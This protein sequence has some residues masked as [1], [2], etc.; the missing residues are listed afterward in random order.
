MEQTIGKRIMENRKRLGLTQDQLAERLGI[1]AQAVSKWE[2]DQSCPDITML[3]RL[4]E[5]FGVST[6]ALLGREPEIPVHCAEVV[7]DE[8]N[9]PE[10][11]HINKGEWSFQW[12]SGRRGALVFAIFVL[13]SGVLMLLA[14]ILQWDVGFWGIV[15]PV[16]LLAFGLNGVFRRRPSV[17]SLGVALFGGY[18]LAANLWELN[19]ERELV[20]PVVIVLFGV[21]FLL[22]ALRKPRKPRFHISQNGE[23]LGKKGKTKSEFSQGENS[24]DCSLHFG[25]GTRYVQLPRLENGKISCAFGELTLDLS[26]VETVSDN[27]S[28]DASCAFGQLTLL[29][30]GTFRV[31][32]ESGTA[33]GNLEIQGQPDARPQGVIRLNAGVRFGNMQIRYL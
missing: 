6:D 30:P 19:L 24:F 33:F 21:G 11:I 10:G 27:C 3:P 26:G 23:D 25:E 12:D 31:D 9:E 22:D 15:W 7:D 5:I 29:V 2:N 8:Q 17:F 4:A 16:G 13:A 32:A 14:R 28:L 1:T 18:S 20:M